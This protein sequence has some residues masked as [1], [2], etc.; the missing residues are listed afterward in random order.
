MISMKATTH[1]IEH[2]ELMP[3]VVELSTEEV[4]A[5]VSSAHVVGELPT[6]VDGQ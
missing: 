5:V 2:L 1:L 3:L 4:V 6:R